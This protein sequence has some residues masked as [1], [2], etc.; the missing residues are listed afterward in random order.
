M[1]IRGI[2]TLEFGIIIENYETDFRPFLNI[3]K[4]SKENGQITGKVNDLLINGV[5]LTVEKT[6]M[7]FYAYRLTCKDFTIGFA[8]KTIHEN[9]HI[10]V[11][12]MSGY[13]WS[14]GNEK[15]LENFMS[16]FDYFEVKIIKTCLSRVDICADT[17]EVNFVITDRDG[18]VTR[19]RKKNTHYVDDEFIDGDRKSV[20]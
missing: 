10:R 7:P 2:D 6:G 14:F 16:W 12:F 11:K 15:T 18:F 1:I 13:L 8:E 9:P 17:D 3:L 20:V 5:N 19:A 4:D